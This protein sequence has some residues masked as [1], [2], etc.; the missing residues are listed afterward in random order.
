MT[1]DSSILI[2]KKKIVND[3]VYGFINFPANKVFDIVEHPWFQR[4]RRIKQLGLTDLVY[5]GAIHTRFHHVLGATHLMSMA[6]E[7]LSTKGHQITKDEAEAAYLAILLHD[8][9]H[10]PF[11]HAL[12][13][14][15]VEIHHEDL[16]LHLMKELNKQYSGMLDLTIEIFTN[17]YHKEIFTP[18]GFQSAR[19]RPLRL[20]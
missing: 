4:L 6:L 12:E 5:P 13:N 19:C 17:R 8:I 20:S 16:S 9:G 7:V 3:P 1:L 18:I 11:S 10:G 2:N 14:Q 15:L